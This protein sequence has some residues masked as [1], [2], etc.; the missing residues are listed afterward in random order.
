MLRP[1]VRHEVNISH[2]SEG[3]VNNK[4]I[5]KVLRFCKENDVVVVADID[6]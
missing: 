6:R 1:R 4:V 2:I 3:K 5:F